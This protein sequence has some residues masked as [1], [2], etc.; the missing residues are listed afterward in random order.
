MQFRAFPTGMMIK[1]SKLFVTVATAAVLT[2]CSGQLDRFTASYKNPSDADPVYTA[3]VPKAKPVART[4]VIEDDQIA[5]T[6][7][8][9]S[10]RWRKA[11]SGDSEEVTRPTSRNLFALNKAED[12]NISNP[13]SVQDDVSVDEPV[14]KQRPAAVAAAPRAK[15]GKIRVEPGMT[16][17]GIARANDVSLKQ[18]ARA[19]GIRAP[20]RLAAGDVITIPGKT[21]V[22]VP[23]NSLAAQKRQLDTPDMNDT[24]DIQTARAS[25]ASPAAHQVKSGETFYSLGRTYGVPPRA[26]AQA[27]HLSMSARLSVG[28]QLTIPGNRT[29]GL[30]QEESQQ[31]ASDDAT[32]SDGAST[33]AT[34]QVAAQ[35]DA[36]ANPVALNKVPPLPKA[37][38]TE[39]TQA[40]SSTLDN[41]LQPSSGAMSLRWPVRGKIISEFGTKPGGMKNEGVNIAVPEGTPIRAAEQGVVAYAGNELKG[42]GNLILIR[43]EGGYVTAY[44]HAKE[45]EVKR[46]DTV[47]RG[48]VIAK[49]GQSGAVSS[50]Q[51]HFEVRKGATALDPIKFLGSSTAAN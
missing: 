4:R 12:D 3:S 27:N 31:V 42:Y 43:H 33:Q 30:A 11:S 50:P 16:L 32:I 38:A 21:K 46:G 35:D 23:T 1:G 14:V 25:S 18:L 48:D 36:T 15:N 47:K 9:P 7:L 39:N 8:E 24:A 28:Q 49:A 29:A 41:P 40:A 5:S 34:P 26:I 6:P 20:Y 37:D 22:R 13:P 17:Y 44:A 10:S 2:G 51:L 45:L 19:N